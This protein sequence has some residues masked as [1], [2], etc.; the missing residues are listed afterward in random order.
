MK[1]KILHI[2]SWV[3]AVVAAV[4]MLQT[5]VFKFSAAEESVYI[6]TKM[7]IEPW[8]RIGSGMAELIASFLLLIPATRW[9][10]ASLG[11]G[12]MAGAICSHLTVLGIE[13]KGDGGLLFFYAILVFVACGV[14]LVLHW[15]N[16][17]ISK[18]KMQFEI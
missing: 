3:S 4:I 8:G 13:V 6:F 15:P 9:F 18:Y 14:C 16:S 5:L 7:G 12:V 17:L 11:I 1:T 10:G 2:L